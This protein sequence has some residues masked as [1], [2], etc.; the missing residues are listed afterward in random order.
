MVRAAG[1]KS[2]GARD[3]LESLCRI[4]RPAVL[5]YIRR[6]GYAASEAEDLTQAFF[7]QL[8]RLRSYSSADPSRG[9]FRVFLQVILRRFLAKQT[10]AAHAL[11]RGG[12]ERL[13]PLEV[14]EADLA[15][16]QATPDAVFDRDWAQALVREALAQLEGE[17]QA[18]GRLAMFQALKPWLLEPPGRDDLS[19]LAAQMGLRGNTL[20]VALHRLRQRL[21]QRV[22]AELQETVDG[23]DGLQEELRLLRSASGGVVPG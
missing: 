20:A 4:Y 8:L 9:R 11:K 2:P 15:Q 6:R 22:R 17:A 5:A 10:A 3:A 13:L 12:G 21:Q 1:G 18:A 23:A 16:A 14:V 7:E 19:L